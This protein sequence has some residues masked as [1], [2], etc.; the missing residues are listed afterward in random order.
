MGTV[1]LTA[2]VPIEVRQP[3]SLALRIA[4]TVLGLSLVLCVALWLWPLRSSRATAAMAVFCA[5]GLLCG[6]EREDSGADGTE[7]LVVLEPRTWRLGD[8]Y[9]VTERGRFQLRNTSLTE[10]TVT[11]AVASCGCIAVGVPLGSTIPPQ[12]SREFELSLDL[13]RARG[14][15]RQTLRIDFSVGEPVTVAIEGYVRSGLQTT[16]RSLL[17]KSGTPGEIVRAGLDVESDDGSEFEITSATVGNGPIVEIGRNRRSVTV[18]VQNSNEIAVLSETLHIE[19]THPRVRSLAVRLQ[20]TFDLTWELRPAGVFLRGVRGEEITRTVTVI[21]RR[22]TP[23]EVLPSTFD[24]GSVKPE[25]EAPASEH[26]VMVHLNADAVRVPG[27]RLVH[28]QTDLP[29]ASRI[30]LPVVIYD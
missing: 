23:F 1:L 18:Y 21:S 2:P 13:S 12:G 8:C 14:P 27:R 17:L 9:P 7:S 25:R 5:L 11:N 22:N 28:I 29:D 24:G 20:A 10:I 26:R 6:C 16:P 19:T 30:A 3:T 15:L 4:A